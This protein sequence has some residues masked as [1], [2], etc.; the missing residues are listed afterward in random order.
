MLCLLH[1]SCIL[2]LME[3][4]LLPYSTCVTISS[5]IVTTMCS[6]LL[7][8]HSHWKKDLVPISGTQINPEFSQILLLQ[9]KYTKDF[10]SLM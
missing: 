9:G 7:S 4:F 10:P 8:N 6:S 5:G 2:A 1:Y 3:L